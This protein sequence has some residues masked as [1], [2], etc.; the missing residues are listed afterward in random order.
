[1]LIDEH[2]SGGRGG[3]GKDGGANGGRGK[4][5]LAANIHMV[6]CEGGGDGRQGCHCHCRCRTREAR[7]VVLWQPS[8]MAIVM[9]QPSWNMVVS[10][11]TW[12]PVSSWHWW[13]DLPDIKHKRR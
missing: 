4:G 11:V 10:S 2:T 5:N 1:M 8:M 12:Q 3:C 9:W 6:R 7:V 13:C